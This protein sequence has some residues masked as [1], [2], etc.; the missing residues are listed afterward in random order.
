MPGEVWIKNSVSEEG[1]A[2][3][4][5]WV[6][7]EEEIVEIPSTILKKYNNNNKTPHNH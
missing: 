6:A 3:T 7:F 1:T 4:V 2:V 5:H